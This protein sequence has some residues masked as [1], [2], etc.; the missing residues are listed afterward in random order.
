[1]ILLRGCILFDMGG[2]GM[3]TDQAIDVTVRLDRDVKEKGEVLCQSLGVSFSVAV[4]AL[5]REAVLGKIPLTAAGAYTFDAD[6][7]EKWAAEAPSFCR[8]TYE[9]DPYFDK[10]EQAELRRRAQD[11]DNGLSCRCHEL[12]DTEQGR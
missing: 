12:I 5:V 3:A 7:A 9:Q 8:E 4:N 11:M 1:M 6:L 2:G 10:N